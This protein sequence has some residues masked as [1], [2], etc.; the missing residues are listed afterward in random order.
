MGISVILNRFNGGFMVRRSGILLHPTSLPGPYGIGDIGK[1]AF[2]F[3]DWLEKAGQT[4]WQVL[5]LGPTGYGDSP[6]ASFSTFAGNPLLISFD[7]LIEKGYLS[8]AEV[9]DCP[10]HN[11]EYIDYGTIIPWKFDKLYKAAQHFQE[12]ASEKEKEAYTLFRD[13]E[14]WWLE[15]YILFMDIKN[16]YDKK[17]QDEGRFGAMWSNYWPREL[18]LRDPQAIQQWKAAPSHQKS[19]EIRAIIQYFFFD[20]WHTLKE[21]ANRK[22]IH[23][24]GD[25]PIF[26]AADSVDVWAHRELFQ[27]DERGQPL[28]V[29]GVPPDYFS[30]TGQLWGNPLYNW[31]RHKEEGFAWWIQRIKANLRLYDYLRVDHFR[32][33]EAYWAVP[34]GNPT[35]EH[36]RWEKAP[37]HEFFKKL[38]ETLGEIPIL[39][40]DLGFITEEVRDLRDSFGLP[41][42]K[43][44]QFAFD[45][46]ENGKDGNTLNDFLPHMYTPN[47][48]VYTG[49]HDNDTLKGWLEKA[50][51][52]ELEFIYRYLGY[53]PENTT[54]ALIRLAMA[55]VSKFCIIPL[56]DYL[57]LGSE[58]RIN[59]PS[60]LGCNWKWRSLESQY[61]L[62]LAREIRE[63]SRLYGRNIEKF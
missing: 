56:Q 10:V 23:I 17:A 32:G 38:K 9:A 37:G 48:V 3:I 57:G 21:Y 43:I 44:L 61:T 24:I 50:S 49:T 29:A 39:A 52:V 25:I 15:D 16:I 46:N 54:K 62:E 47:S 8:E 20:Q 63:L 7:I 40:E 35:A 33:F 28:A 30:K 31:E 60:T 58:A 2:R 14:A 59:T 22:G 18:A 19:M 42:M 12:R 55:S 34:F 26:V 1:S 51:K 6:Y 36:G 45:A 4:L 11:Q 41:G 53:I 27:I 13:Q 5:P